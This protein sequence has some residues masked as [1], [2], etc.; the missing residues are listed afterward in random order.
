MTAYKLVAIDTSKA[1]FTLHCVGQ[2]DQ[3]V[4]RLNLRRP[5]LVA[6][7][8]K[9]PPTEIIMEACGGAHHGAR[10][11]APL[12]HTVRL[13]PPQ[14]VKP[15]VK[16]AKNDRNDAEAIAE[17]A[18]RPN[19]HPVP[20]KSAAQ[21]A[22]AMVLKV[23]DTLVCQRTLLVNTLRGHATEFGVIAAR[24][25][26]AVGGLLMAIEAETTIPPQAR[27]MLALLGEEVAH[28]DT[29]IKEIEVKLLAAHRANP[30]SV[31]L[32]TIPGIGPI[33]ALTLAIEIDAA[34][35]ES[36]RH[37]ASWIGLTPKEHSTGGKQRMGGISRAGNERLRQLLVLGATS[38][39]AAADRPGSTIASA[40]LL[41]LLKR[42]PRKVAAVALANKMA[43]IVWAM[44]KSGEV[45]RS[46]P[47]A[48]TAAAAA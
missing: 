28:L 48:A 31:L 35:F 20:V 26:S 14:Y 21:Q 25:I 13:I 17:A 7:F 9:L 16:R 39:I 23:R 47:A 42:K 40:W 29:R 45:Y 6:F 15:F 11:L 8:K 5:R 2:A 12:G 18:G 44:M 46:R 24:G 34:A 4:L 30:L 1:V 10:T 32:A 38:V 19:I 22:A 3:P 41:N 33:T 43:R 27:E 37:L 36:G